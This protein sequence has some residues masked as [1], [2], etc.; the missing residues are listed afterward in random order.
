MRAVTA[1]VMQELDRRTIM[2]YGISGIELME[3]AG[4]HVAD[5]VRARFELCGPSTV[6]ILAGKGN[7]GGD[8]F[9]V[10]RLLAEAGWRVSL[11]LFGDVFTGD[12]RTNFERLPANVLQIRLPQNY[13]EP[14]T[15]ILESS[16]IIVDAIFGTGLKSG[17]DTLCA[18]VADAVNR[19]NK[20]V[21]AVDIPSGVDAT[22]GRVPSIAIRADITVTF[23]AAKTG[24]FLYPGAEFVGEL[25]VVDI[26]IPDELMKQTSSVTFIDN[27]YASKLVKIRSRTAH[28][29]SYGHCLIIAGSSGKSGAAVLA[30]NSAMR[31]GA[32]LVT[33][34]VPAGI[35]AIAEAKTTEVMTASLPD[36]PGGT[37]SSDAVEDILCL[38]DNKDA[39]AIGPG[40]GSD[41]NTTSIIRR[42]L[43][44]LSVP[45]VL[46]ADALNA[47]AGDTECLSSSI[48]SPAVILTPHPGE[49]AR[50]AGVSIAD[51]EQNR[52]G[53]AQSFAT[54][55]NCFL[56]LKGA[57][58]VIAA[59]D[60]RLSINSSG[61]PG[62]ASGGMGD[63]LTG[64]IVAL[65]G[66]GY[67]PFTACCLGAY[68]HGMAGD[69][70]AA[71]KG[72]IGLIA[73]DV[74]ESLAY[75]FNVLG[76]NRS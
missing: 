17:L 60:G 75:A 55:N 39:V 38:A 58:T 6:L 8:G 49:M 14:L 40:L 33:L 24:H 27:V 67:E 32:G 69:L 23:A 48:L 68:C 1:E 65:L 42:L 45:L 30:A 28:K 12:A 34:A 64:V 36:S 29:G 51:I 53:A 47:I 21:V 26:G 41:E 46:D 43:S 52:I 16:T 13:I 70:A 4:A 50:L 9:V 10:A 18:G 2:D 20:P 7:N 25:V 71:E 35:H 73:T 37:L 72:E 19:C 44:H 54:A 61:N 59:P 56:L 5:I 57:R 11:L 3:S 74:Q 15:D 22:T 62:M 63:V 66:Q 31:S 76:Q